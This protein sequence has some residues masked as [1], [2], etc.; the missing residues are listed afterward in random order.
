[1]KEDTLIVSITSVKGGTGKTINTLNLAGAYYKM[2]KKVLIIDLDLFSGDIA[3]ILDLENEKDIYNLFEDITNNNFNSISDYITKHNDYIDVMCA[4]KDPRFSSKV[5]STLIGFILSKVKSLYDVILID[6]NHFVNAINLT[7]F[8]KS[9][10]ILY[11]INNDLMNLKSMK[12]M[13]SIFNNMNKYNYKILLNESRNKEKGHFSIQDV[14]SV[15]KHE[16]DF[17]IPCNYHIKN[18]NNYIVKGNILTLNNISS[19]YNKKY[20]D[21]ATYL[22]EQVKYEK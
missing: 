18:I 22:L 19:S 12:S 11:V 9:S 4:P 21:I 3:A 1:M 7:A 2:N 20:N 16:I 13:V 5:N 8:D 6:T 15:I 10:I 14:K 17:Y